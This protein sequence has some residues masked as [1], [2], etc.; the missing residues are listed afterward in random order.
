MPLRSHV[1]YSS[2]V[3]LMAAQMKAN[4]PT[5]IQCLIDLPTMYRYIAKL[6]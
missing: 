2:W 5:D 4:L 3:F 1:V 6:G